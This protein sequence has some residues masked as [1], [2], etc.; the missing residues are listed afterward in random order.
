MSRKPLAPG[1]RIGRLV[2]VED[3]GPV[4]PQRRSHSRCRC[5]CGGEKVTRNSRLLAGQARS[6]GCLVVDTQKERSTTHGRINTPEYMSWRA[7]L[8]RCCNPRDPGYPDYGGRGITVDPRWI[9]EGGFA[10]FLADMGERPSPKHSID[11]YPDNDGPYT[12]SNCRWATPTEQNRNR[13]SNRRVTFR[14]ETLSVVEWSE[15]TGIDARTLASRLNS[16]WSIERALTTPI[17]AARS[18]RCRD[19][20]LR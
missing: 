9:G 11:R 4:G 19:E 2:V 16:G 6:C 18:A 17:D 3:L 10:N 13:R 20:V 7:L 1:T 12:K 8:G 5:D 15:R 14:A